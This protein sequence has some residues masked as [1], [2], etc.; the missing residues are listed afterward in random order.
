MCVCSVAKSC[1]TLCNLMDY[2][3]PDSS[4]H[5]ILQAR[6]LELLPFPSPGDLPDRGIKTASPA[7][8]GGLFVT[9]A[10][11]K[12]LIWYPLVLFTQEYIGELSVLRNTLA[13]KA[14]PDCGLCK[15]LLRMDQFSLEM[16]AKKKKY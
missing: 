3:P 2:S 9:R 10:P 14:S 15:R 5:G 4:V 16:V 6:I 12:P 13:H 1:L 11:R 7:L 8:A